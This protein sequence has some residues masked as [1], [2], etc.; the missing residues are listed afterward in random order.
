MNITPP[1]ASL[2]TTLSQTI[3]DLRERI[4]TTSEE[5]VTGRHSDLT[6]HLS[7]SIGTAMLSQKALDSIELERGQLTLR[8]SRLDIA[9]NTLELV[10][11]SA[12]G[13]S[14]ELHS[15]IGLGDELSQT[16][17]ARDARAA[18]EQTFTA[19]NTRHG[20][21]Y[22]FAGDATSTLPMGA[23]DDLLADITT[24][25]QG[26]ATPADLDAA[27]DTYFNDPAGGWQTGVFSGTPSS[28]DPDAVTAADPAITQLISGL[29][30]MALGDPA[31]G[32]P[33]VSGN[34]DMLQLAADRTAAGE[35]A[36]TE[37]RAERGL[38]Q[39]QI[40]RQMDALDSEETVLVQAFNEMT[41]RDQYEAASE[42]KELEANLEASYLLTTRLANLSLLNFMG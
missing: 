2:A 17:A 40:Q 21:R 13:L 41:G 23:V 22:L 25:A 8:G 32:V 26:A 24:L 37:L 31:A 3:S 28:S 33:D 6:K 11:E 30:L 39:A 36:M 15:A 1:S 29:A 7:G 19:L 42:L 14:L 27:L 34:A 35:S 16:A 10:Q 9:Q 20:E 4:T 38:I 18:L 5:A 12:S